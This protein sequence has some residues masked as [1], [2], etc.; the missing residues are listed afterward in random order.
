M[1]RL[2]VKKGQGYKVIDALA[3]LYILNLNISLNLNKIM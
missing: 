2:E 3:T 1:F